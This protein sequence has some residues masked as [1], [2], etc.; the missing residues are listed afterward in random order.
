MPD[1]TSARPRRST[2]A[3][4]RRPLGDEDQIWFGGGVG[5]PAR[6]KSPSRGVERMPTEINSASASSDAGPR[7]I[8][9]A[10]VTQ[11]SAPKHGPASLCSHAP[12]GIAL[13]RTTRCESLAGAS[14][15]SRL[16]AKPALNEGA[17]SDSAS[18]ASIALANTRRSINPCR[19]IV[20]G[21]FRSLLSRILSGVTLTK[22]EVLLKGPSRSKGGVGR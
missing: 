11:P 22:A 12:S 17:T 14:G 16:T 9:G 10:A 7:A 15:Q 4:V 2:G 21:C 1:D 19:S 5:G 3:C 6:Y 8:A 20:T 18:V 13:T